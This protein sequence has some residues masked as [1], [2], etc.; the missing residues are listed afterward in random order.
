MAIYQLG[1]KVEK[2]LARFRLRTV[3]LFI[4]LT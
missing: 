1:L 2:T 3:A 4:R